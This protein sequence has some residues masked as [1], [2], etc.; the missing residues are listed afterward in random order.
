MAFGYRLLMKDCRKFEGVTVGRFQALKVKIGKVFNFSKLLWSIASIF[1]DQ[2][3]CELFVITDNYFFSYSNLRS[4]KWLFENLWS[5]KITFFWHNTV[6]LSIWIADDP[7]IT[8]W[9]HY[10]VTLEHLHSRSDKT[11]NWKRSEIILISTS[12]SVLHWSSN[13]IKQFLNKISECDERIWKCHGQSNKATHKQVQAEWSFF[14]F[15]FFWC[16]GNDI[17]ENKFQF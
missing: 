5:L 17:S 14:I 4:L 10:D 13:K 11:I 6:H 7:K 1:Y 3:F 2:I 16:L 9:K 15:F 8:S 12:Q